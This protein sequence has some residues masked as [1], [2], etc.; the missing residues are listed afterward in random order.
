MDSRFSAAR[1]LGLPA[2]GRPPSGG[3]PRTA[4]FTRGSGYSNWI[5]SMICWICCPTSGLASLP[6]SPWIQMIVPFTSMIQT[7]NVRH[8]PMFPDLRPAY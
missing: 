1:L 8:F 3:S 5:E 6:V 2:A 7:L 4:A